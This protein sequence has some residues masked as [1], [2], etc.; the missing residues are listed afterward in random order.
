[1]VSLAEGIPLAVLGTAGGWA[2]N[3][4]L[5]WWKGRDEREGKAIDA[6]V[7]LEQHTD[8]FALELLNAARGEMAVL[9]NEVDSLRPLQTRVA[10]L[11]EA[12]DHIEALL[13]S[14]GEEERKAAERRATAFLK[15]MRRMAEARGTI[16]N[17][18]QREES[19]RSI[20]PEMRDTLGKLD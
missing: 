14:E 19:L 20:P 8:K 9:K 12:L 15:R 18:I 10:H 13:K 1:M 7:S 3:F 6:K 11:D 5:Q 4:V 2:G 17:E 16:L